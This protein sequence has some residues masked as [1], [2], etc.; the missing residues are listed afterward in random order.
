MSTN[1]SRS[2]FVS[3]AWQSWQRIPQAVKIAAIAI[4]LID[5]GT[6]IGRSALDMMEPQIGSLCLIKEKICATTVHLNTLGSMGRDNRP[7]FLTDLMS[8]NTFE[9]A[10]SLL[11]IGGLTFAYHKFSESTF[12]RFCL[13]VSIAGLASNLVDRVIF[14][15][16]KDFIVFNVLEPLINFGYPF[17]IADTTMI[18]GLIAFCGASLVERKS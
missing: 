2:G 13:A 12:Q 10:F 11:V 7:E 6:K 9:A 3:R 16:V 8:T 5:Q 1:I 4:P 17:N 15:G 18:G 14:G